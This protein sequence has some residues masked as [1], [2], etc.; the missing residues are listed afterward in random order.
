MSYEQD[1]K[2]ADDENRL[3]Q[4]A[5]NN[6]RD[7]R[8]TAHGF[9]VGD[10]VSSEFWYGEKLTWVVKGFEGDDVKLD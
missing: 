6:L 2:K 7:N 10:K 9:T 1:I 8:K 5:L 3:E 4:A